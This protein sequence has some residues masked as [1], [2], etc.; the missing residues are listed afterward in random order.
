[1]EKKIA[2][3]NKINVTIIDSVNSFRINSFESELDKLTFG[4]DSSINTFNL[5]DYENNFYFSKNK[6]NNA[7]Y[8]SDFDTKF[9][10]SINEAITN[11]YRLIE[12]S[13]M[14]RIII[15]SVVALIFLVFIYFMIK[16][17]FQLLKWIIKH[18]LNKS[19]NK[20]NTREAK[21]PDVL[22]Q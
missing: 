15:I 8:S 7:K 2:I 3:I 5:I 17:N 1:M 19:L 18:R 20:R 11:I 14:L 21:P 22:I 12:K 10:Q 6:S 16:C 9:L 4:H 13:G